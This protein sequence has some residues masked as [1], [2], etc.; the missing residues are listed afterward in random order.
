[1]VCVIS[2]MVFYLLLIVFVSRNVCAARPGTMFTNPEI[3]CA[4]SAPS[5]RGHNHAALIEKHTGTRDS[6]ASEVNLQ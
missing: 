3:E 4:P 1:M 6:R 5:F 2:F